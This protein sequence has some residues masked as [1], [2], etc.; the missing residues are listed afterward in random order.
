MSLIEHKQVFGL[1][2]GELGDAPGETHDFILVSDADKYVLEIRRLESQLAEAENDVVDLVNELAD[3]AS[4]FRRKGDIFGATQ[5]EATLKRFGFS[6]AM[7]SK[8]HS[9]HQRGA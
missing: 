9:S 6:T 8:T 5:A 2:S 1:R 7:G 4:R 3:A